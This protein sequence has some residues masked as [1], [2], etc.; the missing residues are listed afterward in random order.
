MTIF[1]PRQ[2]RDSH[3]RKAEKKE[4][5]CSGCPKTYTEYNLVRKRFVFFSPFSLF[6][7]VMLYKCIVV[8]PRQA[9]DEQSLPRQARDEQS[10]PRQA[11]D[12]HRESSL[13]MGDCFLAAPRSPRSGAGV[14]DVLHYKCI[15]FTKTGSGQDF[16]G[17]DSIQNGGRRFVLAWFLS[18][19]PLW[20]HRIPSAG[21]KNASF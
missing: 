13:Y 7:P 17:D 6:V 19:A 18:S 4:A 8:L 14:H 21:A 16:V 2:A 12:K 5:S 3:G 15:M 11:R 20:R 10:L 9:R 1:L